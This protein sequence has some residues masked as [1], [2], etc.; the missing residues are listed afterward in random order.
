MRLW[1]TILTGLS[2]LVVSIAQT[3]ADDA[4]PSEP[5][6][7]LV[8]EMYAERFRDDGLQTRLLSRF[9]VMPGAAADAVDQVRLVSLREL[10]RAQEL[11]LKTDADIRFPV[12]RE[13]PMPDQA[14]IRNLTPYRGP[15]DATVLDVVADFALLYGAR[16][17]PVSAE[18]AADDGEK[19]GKP[20]FNMI[21]DAL[22]S[23]DEAASV[24]A[25]APIP[26]GEAVLVM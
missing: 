25:P 4:A 19:K 26:W 7:P 23:D 10:G 20:L 2:V 24:P 16:P 11:L 8:Y 1:Q 5:A 15:F 12:S 6:G 21:M 13:R 9:E 17:N 18:D 22:S 14:E 3:H